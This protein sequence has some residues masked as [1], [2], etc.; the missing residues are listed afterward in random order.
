MTKRAYVE[1]QRIKPLG[2]EG[3]D[4]IRKIATEGYAKVNEVLV[5]SF[6]ASAIV[7]VY[8]ALTPENQAKLLGF[9]VAKAADIS[10]KLLNKRSA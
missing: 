8:D 6:S 9:P 4:K 3:I 10:F 1:A 2:V 7:A 5:D